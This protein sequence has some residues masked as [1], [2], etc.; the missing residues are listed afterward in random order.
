M[1]KIW[2]QNPEILLNNLDQFYPTR[3]LSK[4]TNINSIARFAIY[5]ALI[6]IILKQNNIWLLIPI[7]ILFASYYL[8]INNNFFFNKVKIVTNPQIINNTPPQ[9]TNSKSTRDNPYMNYVINNNILSYN[10]N[11][12]PQLL[13]KDIYESNPVTSLN[14]FT[15]NE[16]VPETLYSST[17]NPIAGTQ[18]LG[19]STQNTEPG[20]QNT[21]PGTPN[22][23][24]S[25]QNTEPS[26]PNPISSTQNTEPSTQ[27]TK[28]STQNTKPS[29][30]NPISSLEIPTS[31]TQDQISNYISNTINYD[32]CLTSNNNKSCSPDNRIIT[33]PNN[34]PSKFKINDELKKEIRKNYRSHLKFDSIDMWGHLINDRNYY[35]TPNIEIVN[36]QT[37]FAKWCYT[38]N[39]KS[40][41]CKTEGINCLKDRDIRYHQG[42]NS[43]NNNIK[44]IL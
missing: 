6:I 38:N 31:C 16:Y 21:E 28:P 12:F 5:L 32:L 36:D 35:T 20:T 9:E 26:T 44:N 10:S 13:T 3:K 41:Q 11:T 33:N 23:I 22:P 4:T 43:T 1:T 15:K 40:G 37:E 19:P 7:I 42:R 2:Y 18:N 30:P 29:T 27:N 24:P 8:N 14:L 25:T 39:G 17:P 34:I